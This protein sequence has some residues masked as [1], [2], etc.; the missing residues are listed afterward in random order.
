MDVKD[1]APA[2]LAIDSLLEEAN[3]ILNKGRTRAVVQVRTF[4]PGSIEVALDVSL[5]LS[6]LFSW[7]DV[8]NAKSILELLGLTSAGGGVLELWRRLRG[9]RAKEES[10]PEHDDSEQRPVN[11]NVSG[12]NNTVIVV[13]RDVKHLYD[14]RKIRQGVGNLVRPLLRPGIDI[15]RIGERDK[16][17]EHISSH[18]LDFDIDAIEPGEVEFEG[19]Y[20]IDKLSLTGESV[21][22]FTDENENLTFNA[23]IRDWQFRKRLE[24]RM[25][26]FTAGDRLRMRVSRRTTRRGRRFHTVLEVIPPYP[27]E[28]TPTGEQPA[29]ARNRRR[30][31]VEE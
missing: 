30:I 7:K 5:K 10:A 23:A 12:D 1:L 2:L 24:A 31:V 25:I 28:S 29:G 11:V 4:S 27:V 9:H 6:E 14:S 19:V 3:R 15:L 8:E 13:G 26:S 16:D 20:R 17:A 18:D 22:T 21:W